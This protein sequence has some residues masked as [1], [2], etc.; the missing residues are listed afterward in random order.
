MNGSKRKIA[1]K[2]LV[3]IYIYDVK[4]LTLLGAPYIYDISSL[5]VNQF[6][7]LLSVGTK[8]LELYRFNCPLLLHVLAV[9][10][11]Y[12]VDGIEYCDADLTLTDN[13]LKCIEF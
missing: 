5:R 12:Q 8:L 6:L 13:I 2:N 11:H 1:S 4:F 10:G 3:H 7:Y 9:F